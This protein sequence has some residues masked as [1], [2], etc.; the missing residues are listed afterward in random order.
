MSQQSES[1]ATTTEVCEIEV[2]PLTE[3]IEVTKPVKKAKARH[4]SWL[5]TINSNFPV[6][7]GD[8]RELPE[9]KRRLTNAYNAVTSNILSLIE[10]RT[11]DGNEDLIDNISVTGNMEI[12]SER[13]LLHLHAILS[14]KHRTKIRMKYREVT[15]LVHEACPSS[16]CNLK[17]FNNSYAYMLDY[18]AKNKQVLL[19]DM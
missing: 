12:G 14:I 18:I 13:R 7:T 5:I 9:I 16:Y 1:T 3:S 15:K 4:S 17:P 11:D 19:R 2:E 8:E 10:Y 6:R